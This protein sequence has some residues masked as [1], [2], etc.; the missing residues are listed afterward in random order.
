MSDLSPIA[1]GPAAADARSGALRAHLRDPLHSTGY[2][3]LLGAGVTSIL[4]F[5][6]WGVAAREYSARVVG[7]N[8]AAISAMMLVSGACQLG[9]NAVLVRYLPTAG[10]AARAL[11]LRAYTLTFAI[12]LAAG[13]LTAATSGLWSPRLSFLGNEVWWFVGFTLATAAWTLFTLQDSV[14]TG[15][16]SVGW[17]PLEN[18]AYALVKLALVVV[19]IGAMPFAGPFVAWNVP[20]VAM[21][22]VITWLIFAQL[23]PRHRAENPQ[24]VV[25][26]AQIVAVARGNYGGT[27]CSL[28]STMLL[29]IM[30][31]NALGARE[32][33]FFY[34]PWTIS[35]GLLLIALHM[36]TSLTV[37]AA[38][39]ERRLR[40]LTRRALRL[41]LW[42]VVGLAG[43]TA[44]I[45]PP[46][47]DAFGPAYADNGTTLLRLLAAAAVPNVLVALALAVAR[48]Q[49]RGRMILAIQAVQCV[50][51]LGLAQ[52]L[53]PHHGIDGVGVAWLVSQVVVATGVL[54]GPLRP[55]LGRVHPE[56]A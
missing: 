56:P 27:L 51:V 36:T 31:A 55:L 35:T 7:L 26:R 47:L 23:L 43:L 8:A 38:L 5:L 4:G 16:K 33:A 30:V 54:A 24:G 17:V 34:V 10:G 11:V 29:P 53:L 3:L 2:L 45:A 19:L 48:V 41:T 52:V 22:L 40:E 13:A 42:L 25:D 50:L 39:D 6:F 21:V 14:M 28:A 37:Q 46:F 32:T 44:L 9:L 18:S 12:S 1:P 15:L 20:V 49:H